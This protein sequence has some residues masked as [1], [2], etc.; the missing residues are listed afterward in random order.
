VPV[1]EEII[2]GFLIKYNYEA[3]TV[4]MDADM[5]VLHERFI[6]RDETEERHPGLVS[7]GEKHIEFSLD[8]FVTNCSVLRDFSVGEKIIIDTTDLTAVDYS[9]ADIT[10]KVFCNIDLINPP[11]KP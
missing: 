1:C 5:R 6:R 11:D 8:N 3:M 10:I 4:L 7:G 2:N 9:K